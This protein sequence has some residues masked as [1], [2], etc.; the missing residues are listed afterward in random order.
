MPVF[1]LVAS[2]M[3]ESGPIFP[4]RSAAS[5]IDAPMRSLTLPSGL[6]Y[7]SFATTVPTAPSVTR[8]SRTSGVFPIV[9][10]IEPLMFIRSGPPSDVEHRRL[11]LFHAPLLLQQIPD[12]GLIQDLRDRALDTLA[13]L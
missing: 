13:D 10:T 4:S 7:S 2:T 8:F 12:R 3:I 1:P 6:K 5:I 9:S 11:R